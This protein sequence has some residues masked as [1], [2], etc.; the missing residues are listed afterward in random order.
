MS[1]P[2][3]SIIVPTFRRPD[4]LRE[5]LSAL[6]RLDYDPDRYEIIVVDDGDDASAERVLA[7][8]GDRRVPVRL[9]RQQRLGAARARNRGARSAGGEFLLFCDD[10][11]VLSPTDLRARV[12]AFERHGDV[13][14]SARWE[15]SPAALSALRATPFGRYRIELERQF[16]DGAAGEPLADDPQSLR[17]ELVG[18]AT[19]ALARDRFLGIGGFDESFPLAGA[20]DQDF[21]M[22]AR[23]A[24]MTLL[25]DTRICS[26]HNDDNFTLQ[27][28]CAREHRSAQTVAI[29]ARKYPAQLAGTRYVRENRPISADDPPR[30]VAKKLLKQALG[31]DRV[32]GAMQGAVAALERAHLPDRGL[33]R[34]YRGLLGLHLFRGFRQ[35]WGG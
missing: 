7:S 32:L 15:F 5:T 31:H 2:S 20:E 34:L 18:A 11:M 29:L 22:R 14:V 26:L 12:S 23:A 10:D 4:A 9:E 28:Y 21:S 33:R 30:L 3:F 16:Q 27:G 1:D 17:M 13:A 24:E 19:L 35:A 25:L 6:L 8:F